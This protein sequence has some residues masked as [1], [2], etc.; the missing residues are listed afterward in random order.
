MLFNKENKGAAELKEL[1]GFIYK[2]QKFENLIS[3]IGF[4]EREVKNIIGKEV[5]DL[6]DTHYQ[7]ENYKADPPDPDNHPE[8]IVLD[9][10]VRVIQLPSALHAYRRYAP[11]ND[12]THSEKGRQ[13]FVSEDEKPAFEWMINKDD[14]NLL[15][16]AHEAVDLLLDFLNSRLLLEEDEAG[17]AD[18]WGGSDAYKSLKG[19][20]VSSVVE[21]EE[22]FFING[23]NRVLF[24]LIPTLKEVQRSEIRACFTAE[25]FEETREAM[26]DKELTDEHKEIILLI[27]PAMVYLALSKAV[28]RL[29]IEI[30]PN[31]LFQSLVSNVIEEKKP[32]SGT[33]RISL[34]KLLEQEGRSCLKN[35]TEY[36]RKLSLEASGETYTP[37]DPTERMDKELKYFRP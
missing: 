31:G 15:T 36:L 12:V 11:S 19:L 2:S 30:L 4:G 6:A 14:K 17:I 13:I 20:F 3:Y 18:A 7:S 21:F 9:E 24:A 26:L 28:K 32:A 16:L 34:S 35:L 22:T 33:D 37:I 10:L 27:R 29:A 25:K 1:L 5:Y 8:Y 23:S